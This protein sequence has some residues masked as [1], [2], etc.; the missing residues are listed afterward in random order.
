MNRIGFSHRYPKLHGQTSATL[1]A[2]MPIRID[3]DTPQELLEYD[4]KY[5]G[6][7]FKLPH[8]NYI[9]LVFMGNLRIPFCTIRAAWPTSTVE[10]H[11][12]KIGEQFAIKF[13]GEGGEK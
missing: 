1:L 3:K 7:Y 12:S 10:Y 6:G 2:V 8:G 9:Q 13:K 5:D 11:K 4:T